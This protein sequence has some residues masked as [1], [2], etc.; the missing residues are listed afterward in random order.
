MTAA[1]ASVPARAHLAGNPSD[2]YGGAVLSTTVPA[3]AAKVTA[4]DADRFAIRG[5][6]ESW[7][8]M[9]E[10]AIST[11]RLGYE[12]GDRLVRA[13]LLTL[14][15]AL[16]RS[17]ERRPAV[18]EWSTT[19]P[20]SVGL[21]GSSAIVLATMRAALRLWSAEHAVGDLELATLALAAETG[22]LGIAAGIAD[23]TVQALG[24]I[25][26]TDARQ[27]LSVTAVHAFVPVSL[28]LLWRPEAAAPSGDY[29]R[30]LRAAV[31]SGD[32]TVVDGLGRL[33]TLADDAATAVATGDHAALAGAMDDSLRTRQVLGRVPAAALEG[34]DL[35][36]E[37]GAAVNF[38]GS[39]GAVVV[40]G[41]CRTP[42][43]WRSLPLTLGAS[44]T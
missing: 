1:T 28:T 27:G 16:D 36:R 21:G 2:G 34:V 13:A 14:D 11:D 32:D 30:A 35:L 37:A 24:G 42:D 17:I 38:A 6:E 3:M 33:A 12:G 22:G 5:P 43:G 39:G 4:T 23:R 44:D 18:F 19:I 41:P 25:V 40:S 15:G 26:L 10:L 7:A 20:R 8:S 9:T 29:H 31:E